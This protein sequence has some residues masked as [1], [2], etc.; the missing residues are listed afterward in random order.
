MA[1]IAVWYNLRLATFSRMTTTPRIVCI[2]EYI[3]PN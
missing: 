2:K 1:Q 3:L